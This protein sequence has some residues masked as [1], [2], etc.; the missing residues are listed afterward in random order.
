[1]GENV[2]MFTGKLSAL[3]C[4]VATV[5]AFAGSVDLKWNGKKYLSGMLPVNAARDY[6]LSG[7]FTAEKGVSGFTTDYFPMDGCILD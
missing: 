5:S 7:G 4:L 3:L 6:I 2:I 1:M